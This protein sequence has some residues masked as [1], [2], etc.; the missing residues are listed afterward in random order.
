MATKKSLTKLMFWVILSIIFNIFVFFYKG[1]QG[2]M[3]Y[4]GGYII[5]LSLSLDNLF[6]FFM[7][8]KS[9]KI[10]PKYQERVL[11]YGIFGA[12]ILRLIFIV[13]G[14]RV[15]EKFH[16]VLY[17]FGL[18]LLLSGLKMLFSVDKET[19]YKNSFIIKI[20]KI[21]IPIKEKLYG[22]KFLVKEGGKY[23]ATPLLVIL[24]II[25]GSDLIFALDS[26]PAIFSITTDPF[27]VYTSNI[28]AILG[29]RS[30]YYILVKMNSM[31]DY[32]KY[33]VIL[34]L[35]FTGLKLIAL[36]FSVN[37]TTT[38]SILVIAIILLATILIS[39]I[40]D[41]NKGLR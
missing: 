20:M 40:F 35:M 16:F 36:Y 28:F 6:L 41:K 3:D 19:D 21:F 29:L 7:I 31:F 13:L 26:I 38:V 4:F 25:E 10:E 39:L 30:M 8:F 23:F 2:A 27:I 15:I 22:D 14:V 9:F 32:M 18:L 37:I 5:E 24:C 11:T 12:I 34:I 1:P 33:G 17:I